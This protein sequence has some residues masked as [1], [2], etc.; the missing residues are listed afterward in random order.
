[1]IFFLNS[2]YP[3]LGTAGSINFKSLAA[4]KQEPFSQSNANAANVKQEPMS[5]VNLEF[6]CTACDKKFK[7]YCYYKRH[8]DACHSDNPK[9]VCDTCH[10][11]YKWEASFRQHLRSHHVGEGGGAPDGGGSGPGNPDVYASLKMGFQN[12]ENGEGNEEDE[13]NYNE[14]TEDVE[15]QEQRWVIW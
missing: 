4:T 6:E 7:Y 13:E 5:N 2:N 1:M 10:K 15:G 3:S 11:S 12:N 8:M 9:Y 14:Y